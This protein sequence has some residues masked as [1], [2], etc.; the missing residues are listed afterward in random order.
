MA[1]Y[2]PT[3][4][5]RP[6]RALP[7]RPQSRAPLSTGRHGCGRQD[8]CGA[9]PFGSPIFWKRK[10]MLLNM[11]EIGEGGA[12]SFARKKS[13]THQRTPWLR[14]NCDWCGVYAEAAARRRAS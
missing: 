10:S 5:A 2:V 7:A 11:C 3:A 4:A 14:L 8:G 1:I 13:A 6:R 12:K 9:R